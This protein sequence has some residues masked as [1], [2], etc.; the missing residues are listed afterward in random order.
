MQMKVKMLFVLVA[1][2]AACCACS[3]DFSEVR[4]GMSVEELLQ[5]V[6]EPDSVRNDFFN[7]VWFYPTHI[8]SVSAD[9]VSLVQSVA[10]LKAETI[11]MQE[12]LKK[13]KLK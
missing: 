9:T 2:G 1:S 3:A 10:E 7:E 11:R 12:E 6:G 8:V 5:S 4:P 13:I